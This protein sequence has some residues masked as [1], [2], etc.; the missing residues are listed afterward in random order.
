MGS[1]IR[2]AAPRMTWRDICRS[3][4]FAGR[5]I[6]LDN[7]KYV[8]GGSQPAEA[9]VVDADDDL[10]DLCARMREADRTA[11]AILFVEEEAGVPAR[12][13]RLPQLWRRVA[14]H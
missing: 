10:A 13:Q 7:V 12:V 9:D 5:W 2:L 3:E 11:C 1:K 6:A 14:H 4:Q 8:Q